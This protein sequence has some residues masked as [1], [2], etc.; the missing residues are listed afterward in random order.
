MDTIKNAIAKL[1]TLKIA[2]TFTEADKLG[3]EEF[4]QLTVPEEKLNEFETH[5]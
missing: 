2:R 5:I 3:A 1:K 4:I